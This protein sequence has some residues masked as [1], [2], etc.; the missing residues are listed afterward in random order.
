MNVFVYLP[1][2]VSQGLLKA[3]RQ[4]QTLELKQLVD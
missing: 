4:H 3:A 2:Q 1:Q